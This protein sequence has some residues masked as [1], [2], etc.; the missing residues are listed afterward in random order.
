M[1]RVR[2]FA[3]EADRVLPNGFRQGM[4][5]APLTT[6]P[7]RD[8]SYH[9]SAHLLRVAGLVL[10]FQKE[11]GELL[12]PS[13]LE[14]VIGAALWHDYDYQ[15]DTDDRVNTA[16]SARAYL[17]SDD[18]WWNRHREEHGTRTAELIQ[19]TS[20]SHP[21]GHLAPAMD[22]ATAVLQDCD[23]LM[24]AELDSEQWLAALVEETGR[25]AMPA[26]DWYR[27][28]PAQTRWAR[29]RIELASS[30]R[31]EHDAH[32]AHGLHAASTASTAGTRHRLRWAEVLS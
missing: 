2:W 25:P 16:R 27:M 8:L 3:R 20:F 19:S 12:R 10:L 14:A 7:S 23:L 18:P 11:A 28:H 5:T 31:L 32:A 17:E 1:T 26:A 30:R 21:A 24:A 22:V 9:G 29:T 6:N 15:S 4:L 13:E